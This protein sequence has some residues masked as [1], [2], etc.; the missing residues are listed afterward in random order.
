MKNLIKNGKIFKYI[1][2]AVTV[3]GLA[4]CATTDNLGDLSKRFEE[5]KKI[6]TLL[7]NQMPLPKDARISPDKSLILGEGDNWAGRIELSSSMEP[8]EASAFFTTEYPKHNWQLIS[9]TKAKLS[10]LVFTSS[11]R[12]LTLEITEGGP[13][14]AKSMIV[15]T[16][17]PKVQNQATPEPKK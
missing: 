6:E 17:A 1:L 14:A 9:S 2:L 3:F 11:T 4:G 7:F 13:L 16:V 10:I 8:L 15:M 12:T 5:I